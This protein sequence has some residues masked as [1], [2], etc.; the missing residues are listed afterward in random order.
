[1]LKIKNARKIAHSTI[2]RSLLAQLEAKGANVGHFV[3]IVGKYIV[4]LSIADKLKKDIDTRGINYTERTAKGV[5]TIRSNPSVKEYILTL[6]E[7]QAIIK[8]LKLTTEDFEGYITPEIPDEK[9]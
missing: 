5:Q 4:L 1:M 6:K 2:E 3:D 7:M 9:L 8:N